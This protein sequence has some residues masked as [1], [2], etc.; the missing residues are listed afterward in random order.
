MNI[1]IR[2]KTNRRLNFPFLAHTEDEVYR[3][4]E[5]IVG[6]KVAPNGIPYAIEVYSW[7]DLAVIGEEYDTEDFNAICVG[8]HEL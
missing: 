8:D 7:A 1:K 3:I 2:P 6:D 5:A 4:I